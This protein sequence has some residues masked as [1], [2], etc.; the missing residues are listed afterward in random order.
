MCGVVAV[1]AIVVACRA[2]DILVVA[3]VAV[4]HRLSDDGPGVARVANMATKIPSAVPYRIFEDN[5][6]HVQVMWR[7]TDLASFLCVFRLLFF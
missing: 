4:V 1:F 7:T 3:L 6:V 2:K 5:G